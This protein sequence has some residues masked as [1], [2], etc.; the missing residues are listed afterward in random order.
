MN[1]CSARLPSPDPPR[2][3]IDPSTSRCRGGGLV[4]PS[5]SDMT[6][7]E[8]RRRLGVQ[9]SV[10]ARA[11]KGSGFQSRLGLGRAGFRRRQADFGCGGREMKG[12]GRGAAKRIHLRIRDVEEK[13]IANK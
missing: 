3:R 12:D 9:G 5:L 10:E 8:H 6:T 11:G 4:Q 1:L 13:T 2:H 7:A